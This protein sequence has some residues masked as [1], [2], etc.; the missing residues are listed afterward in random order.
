[1]NI[2]RVKSK[3]GKTVHLT[4]D[5]EKTF[6]GRS[7][8]DDWQFIYLLKDRTEALEYIDHLCKKC[9]SVNLEEWE[10]ETVEDEN[11]SPDIERE[12]AVTADVETTVP[13][14]ADKPRGLG[15]W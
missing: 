6:C 8:G 7:I 10:K 11:E 3:T 5:R 15:T 14:K 13:A 2:W 4:F 9:N 1:M 12:E